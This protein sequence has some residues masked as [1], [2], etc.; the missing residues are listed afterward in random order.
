[1]I[2]SVL[3]PN[4]TFILPLGHVIGGSGAGSKLK[5]TNARMNSV[6]SIQNPGPKR[7]GRIIQNYYKMYQFGTRERLNDF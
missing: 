6:Q 2:Q 4:V 5:K 3:P 1:L 7:T